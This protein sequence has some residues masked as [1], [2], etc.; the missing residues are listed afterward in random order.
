[1]TE[2]KRLL[3]LQPVG[4]IPAAGHASR[5]SPSP[6]SKELIPFGFGRLQDGRLHPKAVSHYLL[7]KYKAA[8][9]STAYFILRKGKWDIPGYFG[10]GSMMGM[11]F[12]YLLM[13]LPYGVPYTIE[14]AYPFVKTSKI[15]LGLPDILFEPENAFLL[16]DETLIR[17]QADMVLGLYPPKDDRQ[18]KKCD[19]V[20][21][22]S[23]SG[24]IQKIVVKPKSSDLDYIWVFAVWTPVF[25]IFMHN[26]LEIDRN[27]RRNGQQEREIHFGH[28]IQ[29][30][31]ANGLRVYGRAF[32]SHHFSDIG[33][34]NEL[35]DAW[36]QKHGIHIDSDIEGKFL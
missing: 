4:I 11:N 29:Q 6:C 17:K 1:L 28:V 13:N 30:A 34:P 12:A 23:Q 25:S 18:V 8:G 16:A 26:Y 10:D 19:M 27:R 14:Q 21:W 33:T 9:V 35:A 2:D 31:I 5:I 15:M 24:Q 3:D 20:Q 22:D 32:P 7:D 36:K